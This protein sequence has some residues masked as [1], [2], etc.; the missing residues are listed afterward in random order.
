MVDLAIGHEP[1]FELSRIEIER[2]GPSYTIDTIAELQTKHGLPSPS[3]A[4]SHWFLIMG[5][6]QLRNFHTWH[7]WQEILECVTLAVASRQVGAFQNGFQR[8]NEAS[9]TLIRPDILALEVSRLQPRMTHLP[10]ASMDVSSTRIRQ[11]L[12]DHSSLMALVPHDL[13]AEV[14]DYIQAHQLYTQYPNSN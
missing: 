5:E 9:G 4:Q 7:R 11:W 6:D 2:S 13:S 12:A 14:A 3:L 8:A 1:Q 10:F